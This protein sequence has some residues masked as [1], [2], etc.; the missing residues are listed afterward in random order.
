MSGKGASKMNLAGTPYATFQFLVY[1]KFVVGHQVVKGPAQRMQAL[2]TK[3]QNRAVPPQ[4]F[5]TNPQQ[6]SL[7]KL[8]GDTNHAIHVLP[9]HGRCLPNAA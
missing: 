2:S 6:V 8:V 9:L 1:Q 3:P 4:T 5:A 7:R